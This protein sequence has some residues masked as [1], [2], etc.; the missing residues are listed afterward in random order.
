MKRIVLF[1]LTL[2]CVTFLWAQIPPQ[3]D[4]PRLVNDYAGVLTTEQ[5]N[6]LENRRRRKA[7]RQEAFMEA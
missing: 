3:P 4:P 5:V 7:E 6:E 1:L 2:C